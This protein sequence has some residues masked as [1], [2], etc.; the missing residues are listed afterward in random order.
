[1]VGPVPSWG[2]SS[3]L[4]ATW[5][6]SY[7]KWR[8]DSVLNGRTSLAAVPSAKATGLNGTPHSQRWDA[9]WIVASIIFFFK[10]SMW[11]CVLSHF[12]GTNFSPKRKIMVSEL[13][14]NHLWFIYLQSSST[15]CFHIVE[16]SSPNPK[17]EADCLG[18]WPLFLKS[19][20][21]CFGLGAAFPP[22]LVSKL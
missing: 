9:V 8:L 10:R 20:W 7:G 18:L 17:S 3:W 16:T 5:D 22:C 13:L 6:R 12:W 1:M 2:G 4:T 21:D 15:V 11:N 14:H 19:H